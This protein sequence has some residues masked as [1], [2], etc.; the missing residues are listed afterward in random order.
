MFLGDYSRQ[1]HDLL[2]THDGATILVP[3]YFGQESSPALAAPNGAFLTSEVVNALAGPN[4]PGQY[5]QADGQSALVEIGKVVKLTGSATAKHADGVEVNLAEG[6]PVFQGDV[7]RTGPDSKLG[8]SFLDDS[9]FSMSADARM[10]L[11][12]LVYDPANVANSSMVVNLVQGSFVFVTGAIAPTGNMKVDTPVATMGIRGTTPKVLINTDLGVTEFTILPDPDSGKVGSYLLIDKTS[13]EILGTVESVGDK[14][15]IT[16]LSNEAV[17]V[18]KS[19]LDLLE[20]EV[21]LADIRDVVSRALGDRTELNG[22]NSFQQVAFD[23]SAS[24]GGQGDGQGGSGEGETPGGGSGGV[25]PTPDNDDAPI[26]GDDAFTTT[27]DDCAHGQVINVIGGGA[28]VDPDGFALTVTQVNGVNLTFNST[29]TAGRG[30]CRPV[31]ILA[32]SQTGGI[33]YDPNDKYEWLAEGE[34]TDRHLHLHG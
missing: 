21:A 27:E 20:D 34:E 22:A 18:G 12:E 6:D 2:I 5:A 11:D 9:L 14:W 13:G 15:V 30:S 1:G 31:R 25:D 29:G 26:A 24:T 16:T 8:V 32:I 17:K 33:T 10:V 19:G 7:L 28:D 23:A 3:G 4:A